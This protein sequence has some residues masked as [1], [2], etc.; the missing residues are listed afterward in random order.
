MRQVWCEMSYGAK[1]ALFG[2]LAFI[3][4]AGIILS[5]IDTLAVKPEALLHTG[6]VYFALMA[7]ML[8]FLPSFAAWGKRIW[9]AIFLLNLIL[10]W[11]LIGWIVA[12]LWG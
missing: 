3:T 9:G 11:M 7:M 12:L 8:Y 1:I 5:T 4:I 2:Y 6:G 10:G